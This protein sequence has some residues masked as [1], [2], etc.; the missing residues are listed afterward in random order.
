MNFKERTKYAWE[1]L[2]YN[3]FAI[4]L[5]LTVASILSWHDY[6]NLFVPL[7]WAFGFVIMAYIRS[8]EAEDGRNDDEPML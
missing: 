1:V 4:I 2:K 8:F 6:R 3:K 7:T 5:F